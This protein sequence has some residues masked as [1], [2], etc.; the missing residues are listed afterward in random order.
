MKEKRIGILFLILIILQIFVVYYQNTILPKKDLTNYKEGYIV[1]EDIKKGS[2]ITK[3]NVKTVKIRKDSYLPT[4]VDSLKIVENKIAKTNIYKGEMLS[5]TR[6]EDKKNSKN[7]GENKYELYIGIQNQN[8]KNIKENDDVR[9]FVRLYNK[10]SGRVEVLNLLENKSVEKIYYKKSNKSG[11]I[12]EINQ[13]VDGI[14]VLVS[15]EEL[16]NYHSAN[17]LGEIIVAK[18]ND[19]EEPNVDVIKSFNYKDYVEKGVE[20]NE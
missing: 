1:V 11:K 4:Y 16:L 3:D 9:V 2:E 5:K 13:E 7:E 12:T 19:K 18:Y 8:L 15:D 6:V 10:K 20:V 17:K 14:L